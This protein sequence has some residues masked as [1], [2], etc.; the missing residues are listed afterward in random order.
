MSN[1]ELAAAVSEELVFD[2]KV[3]SG[4]IAVAADDGKVTL[5]G[6]AGSFRAKREAAKAAKRVRGVTSVDNQIDV[7][8]M[9]GG[10]REDADLRADVLR[11]LMLD[12]LV[13]DT[14]DAKVDSGFVRLTG[15]AEWNY[16]RDEA[17]T[18]TSN[19]WGVISLE[20]DVQLLGPEPDADDVE[21]Q[22]KKAIERNAK[23]DADGID[24]E[25]KDHSV[26]L[27]GTVASWAERDDA[28][29]AAWAMPGVRDVHDHLLVE[30]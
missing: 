18:V 1:D 19:V 27:K 11:A 7:E 2:P 8:L 29:A 28:V 13:P 26:T 20:D 6:T 21:H 17:E 9:A 3:D 14:I 16:Q 12:S 10:T 5:R 23:L 4:T 22:I 15:T 24:V 25:T 30:Y